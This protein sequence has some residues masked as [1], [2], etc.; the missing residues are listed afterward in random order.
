MHQHHDIAWRHAPKS[1]GRPLVLQIP[2]R[3]M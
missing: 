1:T 2:R 3:R